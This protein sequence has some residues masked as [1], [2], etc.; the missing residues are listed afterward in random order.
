[1]SRTRGHRKCARAKC[2]VCSGMVAVRQRELLPALATRKL[3]EHAD[4][5]EDWSW[6]DDAAE[7]IPLR[8]LHSIAWEYW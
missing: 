6:W 7:D 3:D 1:M 5:V 4:E 2:G 8:H